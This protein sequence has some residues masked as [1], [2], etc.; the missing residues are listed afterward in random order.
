[1]QDFVRS[2][3][4]QAFRGLVER[5]IDLVYAAARL[6]VRDAHLAEDVTQGV[7][8]LL[9]RKAG[10]LRCGAVLPAWL[11]S[12][13]RNVARDTLKQRGRRARREKEAAASMPTQTDDASRQERDDAAELLDD[14]LSRLGED[15]RIAVT[16]RYL[17]GM[18][19]AEVAEATGVTP[20]AAAK[21]IERAL[22]KMR[23]SFNRRGVVLSVDSI[24]LLLATQATFK[25]PAT[26]AATVAHAA[27]SSG[28]AAAA[29]GAGAKA[30]IAKVLA[31]AAGLAIA[32]TFVV[33][34]VS[35]QQQPKLT[36]F[37]THPNS[38]A[39]KVGVILSERTATG[40]HPHTA[41]EAQTERYDLGHQSI[42]QY[43]KGSDLDV[44]VI[45]E[46]GPQNIFAPLI[47]NYEKTGHVIDGTDA[48]RLGKLDVI[49]AGHDWM[50][51]PQVADAVSKAVHGGVGFLVQAGYAIFDP[52]LT[53]EV[54]EMNGLVPPANYFAS[55]GNSVALTV[56]A[57]H[58]ILR[59]LRVGQTVHVPAIYGVMGRLPAGAQPLLALPQTHNDVP[60]QWAKWIGDRTGGSTTPVDSGK[61][62]DPSDP[63]VYFPLYL[64]QVGKGRM[65]G[66][67]W[68]N[69][70]PEELMTGG[71]AEAFYLRCVKWLAHRP[72]D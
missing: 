34:V 36:S 54:A 30:M 38:N 53:P 45:V 40:P 60:P 69:A 35:S 23:E 33:L 56:F 25:A 39:I 27:L 20:A 66:C 13:A 16:L 44:Y 21:R 32:T 10:A 46:P 57:S 63:L 52:S 67:G 29:A 47:A 26:L 24:A 7:F 18:S 49:V 48:V 68:H 62:N 50:M 65:I 11:M 55:T 43:I 59:D 58:P 28:A 72:L 64:S 6:H 31:V 3:D 15:D 22:A 17:Q 14:G 8:V 9:A 2:R 19:L 61:L 1:M 42:I 37:V 41:T 71:S 51:V 5:H 70:P 4:E 12:T